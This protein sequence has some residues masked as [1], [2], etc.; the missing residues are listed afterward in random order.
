MPK[1][2]FAAPG[3]DHLGTRAEVLLPELHTDSAA[4]AVPTNNWQRRGEVGYEVGPAAGQRFGATPARPIAAQE[5]A[6]Q[7]MGVSSLALPGLPSGVAR[8]AIGQLPSGRCV[9]TR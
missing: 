4:A 6:A 2:S 7:V 5:L 8:E 1:P 3:L 9:P